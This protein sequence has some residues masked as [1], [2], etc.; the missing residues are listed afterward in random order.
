MTRLVEGVAGAAGAGK[1]VHAADG[2]AADDAVV[3]A[4]VLLYLPCPLYLDSDVGSSCCGIRSQTCSLA[5]PSPA[6]PSDP[7]PIS[8]IHEKMTPVP[9]IRLWVMSCLLLGRS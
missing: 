3:G 2:L 9:A 5:S 7:C 4:V 1:G 8:A 6:S